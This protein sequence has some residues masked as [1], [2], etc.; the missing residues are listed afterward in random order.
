VTMFIV[1]SEEHGFSYGLNWS[2]ACKGV[3]VKDKTF[4]NMTPLE[5]KKRGTIEAG[6][7]LVQL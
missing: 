5:L 6:T 2:L 1:Y 3:I 4:Y 7:Q